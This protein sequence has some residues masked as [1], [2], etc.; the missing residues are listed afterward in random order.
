MGRVRVRRAYSDELDELPT[1]YQRSLADADADALAE[2]VRASGPML[3]V[4]SGGALAVAQLAADLHT[5]TTGDLARAVTPLEAATTS[6]KPDT[7]LVL[8]TARG[9]HPDATLAIDA[10][11]TR[12]V[13]HL[14]VVTTR[15]RQDLPEPLRRR[16]VRVATVL[17]RPDGFLA[18]NSLLAMATVLCRAHERD[19]PETL[20]FFAAPPQWAVSDKTLVITA[21]GLAAIGTDLEARLAETGLSSVQLTDYRNLAHGR[22]VGIVRNHEEL[23]VLPLSDPS[24]ELLAGKTLA[25]FPERVQVQ[26][27]TSCL[28][29]PASV[30]DLLVA[31]MHVTGKTGQARAVDPGKPGVAT[32]GRSLYHLPVRRL[33]DLPRPDPVQR[34]LTAMPNEQR[35]SFDKALRTWLA[36]VAATNVRGIVLD[37]DGTCCPTWDRF[38][39]PPQAVQGMICTLL[40]AGIHIGFAT[41]RGKSLH[42]ATRGWLPEAHWPEIQVGLY[43]GSCLLTLADDPPDNSRSEGLMSDVGARLATA[44]VGLRIERRATQVTVSSMT[45]RSSGAHMLPLVRAVLARP[46]ALRCKTVA[47]GHSVDILAPDSGKV[48]LLHAVQAQAMGDV[49]AIGDQGQVDGNDFELLAA[50]A[51]SLSVDLC[52]ADPTRCWN[53]DTH[54]LSGPD[55][56]VKYLR[57][58]KLSRSGAAFRWPN[59]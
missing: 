35:P 10:A 19:L 43:N 38:E 28:T 7:G 50:V 58:L 16:D 24:S 55:L 6:L 29:W 12:G 18:T 5:R 39:P 44:S 49:L 4:G 40:E 56:L 21:P 15:L 11:R 42:Q 41:G 13:R 2:V 32:F 57:S 31:S 20:P 53:L 14:G 48:S 46:P 8:F 54:G 37:Y 59:K 9:R 45:G 26:P 17:S 47:S 33:L 51:T 3:Y 52:S 1:T 34:K 25:L 22:H 23:T 27:L 36:Q 30:L